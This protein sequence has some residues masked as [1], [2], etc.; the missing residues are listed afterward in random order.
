MKPASILAL[1]VTLAILTITI[2]TTLDK[3]NEIKRF[4]NVQRNIEC[5]TA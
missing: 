3:S 5:I 1:W 2:V 4:E